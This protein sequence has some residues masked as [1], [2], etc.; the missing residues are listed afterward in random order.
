MPKWRVKRDPLDRLM[1]KL[2]ETPLGCWAHRAPD[3]AG[4]GR[5]S[6]DGGMVYAHRYAFERM[7]CG[8]PEGLVIDH[9]CRNRACCNPWHMEPVPQRVNCLR[10][11]RAGRRV[12]H[13]KHGH[14]Y[15]P[16]NTYTTPQGYRSCRTCIRSRQERAAS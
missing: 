4:Y 12:T 16:E 8:I 2:T 7:V 14:E 1:E 9:L 3:T 10:G 15:T 5:I 11:D 13:C 6:I